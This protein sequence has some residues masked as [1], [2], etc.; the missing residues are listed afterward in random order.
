MNLQKKFWGAHGIAK[1]RVCH[2]ILNPFCYFLPSF[3]S[4]FSFSP[5]L[6]QW[7]PCSVLTLWGTVTNTANWVTQNKELILSPPWQLAVRNA[8][9]CG[10]RHCVRGLRRTVF[11]ILS[12]APWLHVLVRSPHCLSPSLRQFSSSLCL[13]KGT[14]LYLGG[15]R[16]HPDKSE[17]SPHL[18]I[19]NSICKELFPNKVAVTGSL[20]VC[21]RT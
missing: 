6:S 20:G 5:S 8:G 9:V 2:F 17:S 13:L 19:L 10:L 16:A 7:P 3:L 11:P 21:A 15:C 1:L 14:L 12:S 4:L 18:E